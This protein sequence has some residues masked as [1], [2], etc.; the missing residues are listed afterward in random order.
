MLYT[1]LLTEFVLSTGEV[2]KSPVLIFL[3]WRV[4]LS[5]AEAAGRGRGAAAQRCCGVSHGL[6]RGL[7]PLGPVQST[8]KLGSSV[9]LIFPRYTLLFGF[10]RKEKHSNEHCS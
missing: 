8:N 7:K 4:V 1:D 6:P 3:R 5:A 10:K 2:P 9:R